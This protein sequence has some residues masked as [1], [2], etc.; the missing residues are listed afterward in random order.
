[1]E[2]NKRI[3]VWTRTV[4]LFLL[5]QTVTL[6]GSALVQYAIGW[7]ITLTTQRGSMITIA[8]LCGFLPQVVVSFFAGVWADRFNRKRLILIADGMIAVATLALIIV[9]KGEEPSL[10]LLFVI[11]GIRSFGTG[12]QMPAVS[13]FLPDIVRQDQLLRVNGINA[14]M[15]SGIMLLAPAAAGGLYG[16][17]GINSIFWVDVL[18]AAIGMSLLSM[19]RAEDG[20]RAKLEPTSFTGE[21]AAG[22]HYVIEHIWLQQ[23][24]T[25]VLLYMALIAPA[26]MLT[27]LMV[28]RSF[29][30]EPW[31]LVVHEMVFAAG[32]IGGGLIIGFFTGKFRNTMHAILAGSVGFGV[33]TLIMGFSPNFIFYLALM[34]P[35]GISLPFVNTGIATL[36]QTRVDPNYLGRVFALLTSITSGVM[37]L[38][39]MIYGPLADAVS[40]ES[41]LIISGAC[42][43]GAALATLRRRE[44]RQIAEPIPSENAPALPDENN[45]VQEVD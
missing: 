35:L 12:I 29:G 28:A 1:M 38:S 34:I 33:A 43:V 5:S 20:K 24:F 7:H 23:F 26:S 6:F 14:A 8:A 44:L 27:P 32:T 40:V 42:M 4:V 17:L 22:F 2:D 21:L 3:S 30:D 37:P 25:F 13:A 36:L 45:S 15:Q 18:T 9:S 11:S 19:L 10:W 31:R 16:V 39:M 41:L